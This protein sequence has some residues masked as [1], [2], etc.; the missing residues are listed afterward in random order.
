MAEDSRI[1]PASN[2]AIMI[3]VAVSLAL[4]YASQSGSFMRQVFTAFP[5]PTIPYLRSA[6]AS[7]SDIIVMIL[8]VSLA[9]KRSPFSLVALTGVGA[10]IL[11]PLLWA[12][13]IFVPAI[14]ICVIVAPLA[15]DFTA[16]DF[17][18][19]SIGG[20]FCEELLYRGL[21]ISVLMRW[22]GWH[23]L[24]ACLLPAAFFGAVH[25]WQGSDWGSVLGIVAITGLG[26]LLFGWLFYRWDFN[27]WPPVL[28]HIG[29][30]SLWML[31]SMGDTAIGGWF[32]NVVRLSVVIVAIVLTLKMVPRRRTSIA[33]S[34]H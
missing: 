19:R 32:G 10:D 21:A 3:A 15:T 14:I 5:L 11:R 24:A 31:F 26:G 1:H 22:C 33:L 34:D 2:R 16:Y 12:S 8:L 25:V 23:W 7:V 9:A 28:L 27:I 6:L 13:V 20:P 18:W 29:M 4:I 30:N 17:A